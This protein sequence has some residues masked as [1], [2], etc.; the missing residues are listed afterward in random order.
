MSTQASTQDKKP[1]AP[2]VSILTTEHFTMQ[3]ARSATISDASSRASLY[4]GTLSGMLLAL[5][6][7]GN[8]TD[9]GTPFVVAAFVLA[10]TLVFLGTAT[11]ARTLELAL[12]DS[13][14]AR[15]INRLRHYYLEAAPELRPYFVLSDRDDMTGVLANMGVARG[16]PFQMLLT[17]AGTVG[18]VNSVV[19]GSLVGGVT[20][21][22][23]PA[24]PPVFLTAAAAFGLSAALHLWA[25]RRAWYRLGDRH[26]PLFPSVPGDQEATPRSGL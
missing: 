25:Q 24:L 26:P 3:G 10:P 4:L 20:A 15:G 14:Y 13:F 17:T 21:L 12:E 6:L 11:F 19:V 7:L 22:L 9:L 1:D 2:T 18:V 8:A 5:S 23:N 16:G